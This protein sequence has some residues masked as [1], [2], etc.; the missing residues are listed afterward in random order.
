MDER[1]LWQKFCDGGKIADY[2]EYRS[3]LN[4]KD[5]T[6]LSKSGENY[7]EGTCDKR[8]DYR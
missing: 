3:C 7:R 4:M 6:E 2:L 8:T 5:N 1:E